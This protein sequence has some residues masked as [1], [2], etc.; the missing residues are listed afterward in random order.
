ME[1]R[2]IVIAGP[3]CSGKTS[4]SILL[5]KKL[6][7]EV[8]SADSR[9]VYK[10]L[11]IGTAKPT[12]DEMQGIPHHFIDILDPSENYNAS[13]FE[14]EALGVIDEI[15][16]RGMQP[17]A[18]GGTGLYIR[19]LVDGIF[20]TTQ[21]DEDYR[22]HLYELRKKHGNEYLYG[23]LKEVDPKS[24]ESMLPQNWKRVIRALEVYHISGKPIWRHHE[25]QPER[26]TDIEFEQYGLR[27]DRAVLYR[28]IEK[29]VDEMIEQGLVNE[30][31]AILEMGYDENLNALNTVGYKEVIA[32]LNNEI[33]LDRAI[34][35]IKRNTRRFAKR[36]LTWF[37]RD[38]RI[39]WID[40]ANRD[41][42]VKAADYISYKFVK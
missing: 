26:E 41:D 30:V 39:N 10:H 31:K 28:N 40:I 3:T 4:L 16:S 6:N 11:S 24:A 9:Q 17:I 2:V 37:R 1:K 27:W 12:E 19:G 15:I 25:E 7:G 8:I 34:E 35:L 5:A 13:R 42:I 14:K 21:S 23:M 22:G 18:A 33:T 36:Q 20:D 29:R 32:Y 38:D